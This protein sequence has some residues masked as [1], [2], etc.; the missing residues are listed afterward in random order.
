MGLLATSALLSAGMV[1]VVHLHAAGLQGTCKEEATILEL[2][3]AGFVART[4]L[5]A[6]EMLPT[7]MVRFPVRP[8]A[9]PSYIGQGR[10][11]IQDSV[12]KRGMQQGRNTASQGYEKRKNHYCL[13]SMITDVW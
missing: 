12:R 13:T 7:A 3:A 9:M 11:G 10:V 1:L 2:P 6:P 5:V 8:S 4:I